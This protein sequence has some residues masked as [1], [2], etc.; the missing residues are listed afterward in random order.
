MLHIQSQDAPSF[1]FIG[2]I[3]ATLLTRGSADGLTSIELVF[4]VGSTSPLH[5]HEDDDDSGMVLEGRMKTWCDG[6]IID[7]APG[8]WIALPRA[9]PHAQ[10]AVGDKPARVLAVY[11]NTHFADFIAEVGIPT[12]RASSPPGPPAPAELGRLREIAARHALRILGPAPAD[13]LGS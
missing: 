13:L 10:L 3:R 1:W 9:R 6:E 4:P 12:N 7:S 5:V 2:G 8:S 11:R